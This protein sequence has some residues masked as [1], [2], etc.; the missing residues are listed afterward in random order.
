M[1]QWNKRICPECPKRP[2]PGFV[3]QWD[4]GKTRVI[5][6]EYLRMQIWTKQSHGMRV[7]ILLSTY[8]NQ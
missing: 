2:K 3:G 8:L 7:T 4:K 6:R 1:E 5:A